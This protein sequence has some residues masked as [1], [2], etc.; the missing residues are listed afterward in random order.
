MRPVQKIGLRG[1]TR[2]TQLE[3]IPLLGGYG[4]RAER[5]WSAY[6]T[7]KEEALVQI[8]AEKRSL[9]IGRDKPVRALFMKFH[10]IPQWQPFKQWL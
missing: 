8:P 6:S 7:I 4:G 2:F 1:L 3:G 10:F 5:L 9:P